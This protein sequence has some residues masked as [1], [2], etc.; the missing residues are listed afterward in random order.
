MRDLLSLDAEGLRE[1][2]RRLARPRGSP[3]HWS[4]VAVVLGRIDDERLYA[5]WSG[6]Q[7]L[8]AY[9]AEE[10]G[11]P[12]DEVIGL[13]KLWRMIKGAQTITLD[14]WAD[15]PRNRATWIRKVVDSGGDV[16][17]WLARCLGAPSARAFENMARVA[18]G[19][20]EAWVKVELRLPDGV[21]QLLSAAMTKSLR[22][23]DAA[24][25]PDRIH[26]RDIAFRCV[27][28]ICA[29]YLQPGTTE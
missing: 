4:R 1:E 18:L 17:A 3:D 10:L 14:A 7:S 2:A 16:V 15:V 20:E 8:R 19:G 25:E 13:L 6:H 24:L 27:E 9:A 29:S 21:A 11:L 12:G 28:V 23:I 26:D 22:M 5:V